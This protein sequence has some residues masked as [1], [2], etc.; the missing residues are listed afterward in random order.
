ME[1]CVHKVQA[2]R[3]RGRPIIPGQAQNILDPLLR[4]S[5]ISID[6][7]KGRF[8]RWYIDPLQLTHIRFGQPQAEPTLL[9]GIRVPWGIP[10]SYG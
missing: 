4:L 3:C 7:V 10:V 1:I 6:V 9:A 8:L 5:T 2:H